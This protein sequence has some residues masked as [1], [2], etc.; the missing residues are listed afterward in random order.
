[1]S[2]GTNNDMSMISVCTGDG[3]DLMLCN[4]QKKTN[5]TYQAGDNVR[6]SVVS[7]IGFSK[8]CWVVFCKFFEHNNSKDIFC[9]IVFS[10]DSEFSLEPYFSVTASVDHILYMRSWIGLVNL[11]PMCANIVL[12]RNDIK[13]SYRGY[14]YSNPVEGKTPIMIRYFDSRYYVLSARPA[15]WFELECFGLDMLRIF[16]TNF[17]LSDISIGL[18]GASNGGQVLS[19]CVNVFGELCIL[20]NTSLE[21]VSLI[22][23]PQVKF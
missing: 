9:K 2:T 5:Q 14:K 15:N 17:P 7:S 23:L 18:A 22:C 13:R 19:F 3:L 6:P 1:M 12:A 20:Y 11:G 4:P 16:S 21:K 10:D 8:N